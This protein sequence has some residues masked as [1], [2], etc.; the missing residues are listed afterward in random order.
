LGKPVVAVKP[1]SSGASEI[2]QLTSLNDLSILT[3]VPYRKKIMAGK[4]SEEVKRAVAMAT[5]PDP[6]QRVT[7]AAAA[8]ECGCSQAAISMD[9]QYR[10]FKD[11]Q[12]AK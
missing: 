4:K 3:E 7:A 11:A 12:N 9:P 8:R 5:H 2:I 10:K 6:A 1:P